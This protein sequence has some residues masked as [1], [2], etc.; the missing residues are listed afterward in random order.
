MGC[1]YRMLKEEKH[2]AVYWVDTPVDFKQQQLKKPLELKSR[3]FKQ[4]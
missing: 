1:S 2:C 3:Q 4:V